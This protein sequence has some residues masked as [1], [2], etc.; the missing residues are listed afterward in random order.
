[1]SSFIFTFPSFYVYESELNED[2]NPAD[3]YHFLFFRSLKRNEMTARK[4]ASL[5]GPF[6]SLNKS[7]WDQLAWS[8]GKKK[9]L[10][11]SSVLLICLCMWIHSPHCTFKSSVFSTKMWL[12]PGKLCQRCFSCGKNC[13]I[14]H[15]HTL[16]SDIQ[17]HKWQSVGELF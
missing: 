10:P 14:I 1:M 5:K 6:W 12:W 2:F 16:W 13:V 7:L 17:E 9:N 15:E 4:I 11:V 3:L 8:Y